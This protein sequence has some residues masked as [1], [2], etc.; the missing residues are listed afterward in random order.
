M[1][2]LNRRQRKYEGF[3]CSTSDRLDDG[4]DGVSSRTRI[5]VTTKSHIQSSSG[6]G[7]LKMT[8][9]S[10]N[11]G[12]AGGV[13]NGPANQNAKQFTEHWS[14]TGYTS[15][16]HMVD[17]VVPGCGNTDT[18]VSTVDVSGYTE[19]WFQNNEYKTGF[20]INH[21]EYPVNQLNFL[22]PKLID[23]MCSFQGPCEAWID[24]TRSSTTTTVPLSS[25]TTRPKIP[26][27]YTSCKGAKCV[28]T[29]YWIAVD[30][31]DVADLQYVIDHLMYSDDSG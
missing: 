31:A 2:F 8:T 19:M 17:S 5:R 14:A 22:L 15:L 20:I 30:H 27:D 6:W 24:E 23:L 11:Q 26:T 13:Y 4:L 12:F 3:F 25:G 28:F 16:R 29:F 1:Q 21:N 10:I 18:S 7:L 9:S